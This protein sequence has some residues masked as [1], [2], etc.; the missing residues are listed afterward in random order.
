M[1]NFGPL[2]AEI[3]LPV[4]GTPANFNGFRVLESLLHRCRSTDVN[5]T[6]PDV[7]PSLGLVHYIYT[8]RDCCPE[9]IL[10]G[11]KF[12]LRP[13]LAFSYT[14]SLT[15]RH[16]ISGHQ[17]NFAAFSR[18][19][20]LYSA[21][22]SSRWAS[23]HIIVHFQSCT[24]LSSCLSYVTLLTASTWNFVYTICNFLLVYP[25]DVPVVF[26][27]SSLVSLRLEPDVCSLP[28]QPFPIYPPYRAERLGP[29]L[30][31]LSSVYSFI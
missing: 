9:R 19:R 21:G 18:G 4:C 25:L 1:V 12:T 15:A 14:G 20:H 23:A 26:S 2:V 29:S 27:T 17:P 30:P 11:A 8:T 6:L 22:R 13:N 28:G 24:K 10:T 31:S 7:W 16:S 3:G 5:Q